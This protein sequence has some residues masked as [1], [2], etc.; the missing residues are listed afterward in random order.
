MRIEMDAKESQKGLKQNVL[1]Q[2]LGEKKTPLGLIDL[3][4]R[5]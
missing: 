1:G 3:I 4:A 5:E 2:H